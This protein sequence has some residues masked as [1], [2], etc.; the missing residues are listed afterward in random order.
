MSEAAYNQKLQEQILELKQRKKVVIFAHNYQRPEIQAMADVIGDSL[1]LAEKVQEYPEGTKILYAAVSFMAETA[2]LLNPNALIYFPVQDAKCPMAEFLGNGDIVKKYREEHPGI[3]VVLYINS[4]T[5][6]KQYADCIC[7]S[8]IATEIC[9]K[10]ANEFHTN[11]IGFGPDKN[12][13]AFVAKQTGLQLDIIPPK[14][15]CIVHE[16]FTTHDVE[17]FRKK[18]PQ[19][20]IIVHPECPPAVVQAADFIGSTAA[21]YKYVVDHRSETIGVGTERGLVDRL[22]QEYHLKTVFPLKSSAVCYTM[23]KFTLEVIVDTLQNI[24][25]TQLHVQIPKEL[26][27]NAM[28]SVQKMFQLIQK[29]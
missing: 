8:S 20:K 10:I 7:T 12:L 5:E 15:H 17:N 22:R 23:K 28:K 2:V 27:L 9:A 3:P 19:S 18:Y 6:A 4:T 11:Y 25:D 16:T 1:F 14:G 29:K 13:G 21:L 26:R 24:E